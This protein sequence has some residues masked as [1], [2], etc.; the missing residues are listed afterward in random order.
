MGRGRERKK[1]EFGKRGWKKKPGIGAGKSGIEE[2]PSK[3]NPNPIPLPHPQD[4]PIP[5]PPPFF[6]SQLPPFPS[7]ALVSLTTPPIPLTAPRFSRPFPPPSGRHFSPSP[8][9]PPLPPARGRPH[10]PEEAPEEGLSPPD[11]PLGLAQ[12]PLRL[13]FF[14]RRR[15]DGDTAVP[16]DPRAASR[17]S[18]APPRRPLAGGRTQQSAAWAWLMQITKLIKRLN[19]AWGRGLC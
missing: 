1:G 10:A 19:Q 4:P 5:L 11:L 12:E 3:K 15:H 7:P 9:P 8:P 6:P 16:R 17:D 2:I 13:R 18:A 14:P